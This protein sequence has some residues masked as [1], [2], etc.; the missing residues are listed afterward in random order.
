MYQSVTWSIFH[1]KFSVYDGPRSFDLVL[2]N[3]THTCTHTTG[4]FR[5]Y[6]IRIHTHY[7]HY[8]YREPTPNIYYSISST[9]KTLYKPRETHKILPKAKYTLL[10]TPPTIIGSYTQK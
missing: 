4:T 7:T 5:T 6:Y 8:V 1:S 10:L 2:A 9:K 3:I